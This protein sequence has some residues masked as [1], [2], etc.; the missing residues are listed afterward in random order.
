MF[1][2]QVEPSL[3]V[4][5]SM[6]LQGLPSSLMICHIAL[7][8]YPQVRI[9]VA[10]LISELTPL[11][12]VR[13][14][15]IV[16]FAPSAAEFVTPIIRAHLSPPSAGNSTAESASPHLPLSPEVRTA[17]IGPTTAAFLHDSLGIHV[18]VVAPTP[19]P[20]SLVLAINAFEEADIA[21]A[22]PIL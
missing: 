8:P 5:W 3:R 17:V 13:N 20:E 14:W 1:F 2:L 15:W 22:A 21:S 19:T 10:Q 16:Y 6:R 11:T 9:Y 7:A 4:S 18:D 12:A